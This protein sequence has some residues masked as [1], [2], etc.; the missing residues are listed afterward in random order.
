M[1]TPYKNMDKRIEDCIKADN[2]K[3]GGSTRII[4]AT[5]SHADVEWGNIGKHRQISL[6]DDQ[7]FQES[8]TQLCILDDYDLGMASYVAYMGCLAVSEDIMGK[9]S[10]ALCLAKTLA[11]TAQDYGD[12]FPYARL[13]RFAAKLSLDI[14][15][16]SRAYIETIINEIGALQPNDNNRKSPPKAQDSSQ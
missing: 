12:R 15:C 5:P 6:E 10:D 9:A 13:Q 3:S 1:D 11:D 7:M 4:L 16:D 8:I 14:F 2:L